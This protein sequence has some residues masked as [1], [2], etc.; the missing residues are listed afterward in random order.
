MERVRMTT[1][2]QSDNPNVHPISFG[3]IDAFLDAA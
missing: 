2:Q 1:A 3:V